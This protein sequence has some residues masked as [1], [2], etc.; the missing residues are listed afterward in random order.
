[1]LSSVTCQNLCSSYKYLRA[2]DDTPKPRFFSFVFTNVDG[3][4][5]YAA[6]LTFYE[7]V[8]LPAIRQLTAQLGLDDLMLQ[9]SHVHTATNS[10]S[11]GSIGQQH[12][13]SRGDSDF[14]YAEEM[15]ASELVS[16]FFLIHNGSICAAFA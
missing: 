7:P 1:M 16:N 4:R 11:N 15:D 8:P 6:C 2:K 10:I 5:T 12:G 13:L 3:R 14:A 9:S